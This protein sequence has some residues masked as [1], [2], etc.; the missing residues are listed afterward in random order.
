MCMCVVEFVCVYVYD[1]C[2]ICGEYVTV[3]WMGAL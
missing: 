1:V 2:I 3:T